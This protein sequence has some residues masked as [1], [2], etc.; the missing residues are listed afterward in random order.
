[1]RE[2]KGKGRGGGGWTEPTVLEKETRKDVFCS[3]D[4]WQQTG[5]GRNKG[6]VLFIFYLS[7]MYL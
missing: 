2:G 5:P 3:V 4:S 1:M 7:L 6:F